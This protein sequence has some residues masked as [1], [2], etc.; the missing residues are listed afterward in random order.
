MKKVSILNS[1]LSDLCAKKLSILNFPFSDLCAKK[2]SILNSPFSDYPREDGLHS[3]FVIFRLPTRRESQF[4][5]RH[6]QNSRMKR[7]SIL[8]SLFLNPCMKKA[9]ILN[10]LFLDLHTKKVSILNSLFSGCPHE[11]SVHSQFAILMLPMQRRSPFS[12]RHS[13]IAST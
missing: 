3:Q 8:N 4:S 7:V 13:Q 11:D 10:S 5:T 1:L 12:T 6:S 9:S 2:V